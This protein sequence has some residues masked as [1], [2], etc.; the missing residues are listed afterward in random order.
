M[1]LTSLPHL[2]PFSSVPHTKRVAVNSASTL[3]AFYDGLNSLSSHTS[4][5]S[6]LPQALECLPMVLTG[7]LL[8]LHFSLQV[9]SSSDL[10]RP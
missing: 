6:T 8:T 7:Q 5:S 1:G 2:Q 3:L 9:R 10:V 4:D